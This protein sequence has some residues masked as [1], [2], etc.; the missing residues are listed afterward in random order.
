[1]HY[2]L[3]QSVAT[4]PRIGM[5]RKF[6]L[7][8]LGVFTIRD[9]LLYFPYKFLR[10]SD[11]LAVG[12]I[13]ITITI[14]QKYK[15][16]KLYCIKAMY[17]ELQQQH[18]VTLRF[19]N[20]KSMNF[21]QINSKH[22]VYGKLEIINMHWFM[23]QPRIVDKGTKRVLPVYRTSI[24]DI[25]LNKTINEVIASLN[26]DRK[27]Y[28]NL[29]LKEALFDLHNGQLE[30]EPKQVLKYIEAALFVK[31]FSNNETHDVMKIDRNL[32]TTIQSALP[33][34]LSEDQHRAL[35]N[36]MA[37]LEAANMRHIIFGEV[38][39][40][41]TLIALAAAI[42]VMRLG[43]NVVFLAPTTTLVAQHA[44]NLLPYLEKLGI[45]GV[46]LSHSNSKTV[47]EKIKKGEY[48][49]IIGTHALFYTDF[50][51]NVG[52][53][54]IDEMHKFGVLQRATLLNKSVRKNLLMLSATPIPRS[55][56]IL[57]A[58]FMNFSI[59]HNSVF[60][61]QIKTTLMN[62][63]AIPTLIARLQSRGAKTF[64]VLPSIDDTDCPGVVT[65][66]EHLKGELKDID[67]LLLH[68]RLNDAEKLIVMA[69]F[70][71]SSK[72]LL[73]S[74]TIIEIGID[75][76]DADIIIIEQAQQFG[77][78]QLHQLRGRVGR[79]G[80]PA[81]CI[82][83]SKSIAGYFSKKLWYLKEYSDGYTLA[84]KDMELRGCGEL[85]G[86]RQHGDRGHFAFLDLPKDEE[87]LD[88]VKL[89]DLETQWPEFEL[90]VS[91]IEICH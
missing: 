81:H 56:S 63:D 25:T 65:R 1:M 72:A 26:W 7:N 71:E 14:V 91:D 68:G 89:E 28:N 4:L 69:K 29:S 66:F 77:I 73:V 6:L 12:D 34:K 16:G 42:L 33:F 2:N 46:H 49:C 38:G 41:K 86:T 62:V 30:H 82:L 40:G 74:T 85:I 24:S 52:L 17:G 10:E 31:L 43:F 45:E 60:K 18:Q 90:F 84:Q 67:V 19:F 21:F 37:D 11:S 36:I 13:L 23:K 35:D 15:T 80:Q 20:K 75:V 88:K 54:I 32:M 5:R 9:L 59:I 22:R 61:K 27:I 78:S 79:M 55:L 64:W 83:L 57:L 8:K 47:R 58:K 51:P 53:V 44:H 48:R 70:R 76:S 87:L 50:I 39:A 3:E